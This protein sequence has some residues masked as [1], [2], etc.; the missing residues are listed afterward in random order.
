MNDL[1]GKVRSAVERVSWLLR[2][3]LDEMRSLVDYQKARTTL[4]PPS[5]RSSR[6]GGELSEALVTAARW[7]RSDARSN[8]EIDRL[9][10]GG[11][12]GVDATEQAEQILDMEH[13]PSYVQIDDPKWPP[14]PRPSRLLN[15]LALLYVK[16]EPTYRRLIQSRP[17]S[18]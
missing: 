6:T 1:T 12:F 2:F 15:V 10:G 14:G 3:R 11:I 9:V 5:R 18:R 13:G 7:S 16:A 8:G 17:R 4:W